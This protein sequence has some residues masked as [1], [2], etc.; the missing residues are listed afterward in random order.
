M[1]RV[2]TFLRDFSPGELLKRA[3]TA[4]RAA[5][6]IGVTVLALR[7]GGEGVSAASRDEMLAKCAAGAYVE[8]EVDVL[9]YEQ[10]TGEMNR[11]FVRF[12][13]GA[14]VAMGRTGVGRPFLRD[15]E[16]QDAMARAGTIIASRTEKRGEGDYAV[17]Q[18]AKL[19]APWAVE[20]A[21][22]GLLDTV[23][24]G[25]NPT[26]PV[27]CSACDAAIFS[28]CYHFPGDRLAE[29]ANEDGSKRKVRKADGPI[30]V[31]WIFTEA[32][33]VETSVVS[34]PAVPS[35]HIE[36]IRAALASGLGIEGSEEL[37]EEDM[38]KLLVAVIGT[39]SLAP[40]AGEEEA[41]NA[42]E[43]LRKDRDTKAQELA[44]AEKDYAVLSAENKK[45]KDAET[46]SLEEKFVGDAVATG[47]ITLGDA[48][49]WRDLFQLDAKRAQE[50]M[51]KR[52]ANCATPVGAALQAKN[53]IDD[54]AGSKPANGTEA[55][56]AAVAAAAAAT[57]VDAKGALGFATKFGAKDPIGTTARA[58]GAGKA[59]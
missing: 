39:L 37:R 4:C 48:D 20:L 13:D 17:F 18:T 49:A 5:V 10:K 31:E 7:A 3:P 32:E 43:A 57:G 36:G 28:R 56:I 14:L 42:V 40:T 38:N 34:V 33:L 35:A 58:L 24:I 23:S 6:A 16:Q 22:R 11:N 30:T 51:G 44:I 29:V 54:K 46:K 15:H 53:E 47:R 52:A 12:R 55:D 26:A 1:S 21:L 45:Y 25:W 9:A 41:I 19:T 59:G 8:L 27:M 2:P 50:R